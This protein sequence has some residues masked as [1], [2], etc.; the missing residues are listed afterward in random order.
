MRVTREFARFHFFE[1]PSGYD[2]SRKTGQDTLYERALKNETGLSKANHMLQVTEA[3]RHSDNAPAFVQ[4]LAE[5]GYIL[6]TGKRPYVL[7]DFYGG[8][9]DNSR[10]S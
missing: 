4:A 10:P 7:V 8:M 2:A 5:R 1:L 3:W 6:A 9:H